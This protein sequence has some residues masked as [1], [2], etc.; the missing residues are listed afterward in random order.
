MGRSHTAS[1][2]TI[3]H[4][5]LLSEQNVVSQNWNVKCKAHMDVEDSTKKKRVKYFSNNFY[6]FITCW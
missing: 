2:T 6:I 1:V 4:V 3:S 5:W